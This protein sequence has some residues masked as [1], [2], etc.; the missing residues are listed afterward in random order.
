MNMRRRML[1]FLIVILELGV[2]GYYGYVINY[3]KQIKKKRSR[4]IC[5]SNTKRYCRIFYE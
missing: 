5:Y 1:F 3:K 2:I 4:G